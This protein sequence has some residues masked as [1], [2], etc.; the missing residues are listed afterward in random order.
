MEQPEDESAGG[1]QTYVVIVP[2]HGLKNGKYASNRGEFRGWQFNPVTTQPSQDLFR[3][4]REKDPFMLPFTSEDRNGADHLWTT[5]S[6]CGWSLQRRKRANLCG[7]VSG[8]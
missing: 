8:G 2:I 5:E 1:A 6:L 3:I 4:E 7:Q